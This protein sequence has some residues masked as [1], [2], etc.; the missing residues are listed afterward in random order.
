M[1]KAW[2]SHSEGDHLTKPAPSLKLPRMQLK[3]LSGRK[4]NDAVLRKGRVWKGKTMAVRW[5]PGHPKRPHIDRTKDAVY[6]GTLA[7]AKLHKS[8]VKRNRMR[9]RCREAIRLALKD[10]EK[11]PTAQLLL[12][13]RDASLDASFEM[14][15][16][17]ISQFLSSL[18]W[19]T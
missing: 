19:P 13:P 4:V 9:R 17:D 8:A 5:L 2:E 1:K 12:C 7:S 18:P 11:L 16:N 15:Q 10:I 3:R 6:V 14:I